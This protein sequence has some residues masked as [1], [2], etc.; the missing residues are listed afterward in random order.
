[1]KGSKTRLVAPVLAETDIKGSR[2]M[3]KHM[4]RA[5][6]GKLPTTGTKHYNR[7]AWLYRP[8]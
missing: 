3:R 8:N 7:W 2:I 5:E 4:R 6:A 1:M